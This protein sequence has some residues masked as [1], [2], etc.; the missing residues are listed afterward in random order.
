MLA[1]GVEFVSRNLVKF[2]FSYHTGLHL[3]RSSLAKIYVVAESKRY[4]ILVACL[5]IVHQQEWLSI[6]SEVMSYKAPKGMQKVNLLLFGGVGAGKSSIVATL[7]SIIE[8][9]ISRM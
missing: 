4:V 2:E 7:D 6:R 3:A 1:A 8:G 9:R 5:G